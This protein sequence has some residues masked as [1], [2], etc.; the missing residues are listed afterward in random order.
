MVKT[1]ADLEALRSVQLQFAALEAWFNRAESVVLSG[2]ATGV[3]EVSRLLKRFRV[4]ELKRLILE[5]SLA[6]THGGAL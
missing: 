2:D 6:A 5:D 3:D 1:T 4:L